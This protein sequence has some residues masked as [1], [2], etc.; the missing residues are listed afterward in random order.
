MSGSS[1]S[2]VRTYCNARPEREG[3]QASASCTDGRERGGG[4]DCSDGRVD[5]CKSS[6]GSTRSRIA[7]G[8]TCRAVFAAYL[9][10]RF[11]GGHGPRL[12]GRHISMLST[13][14]QGRQGTENSQL[15]QLPCGRLP[16][17]S[18]HKGSRKR[19][20]WRPR[21]AKDMIRPPSCMR[22]LWRPRLAKGAIRVPPRSENTACM[23]CRFHC[24]FIVLRTERV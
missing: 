18:M 14:G 15:P 4:V 11:L 5:G 13:A 20:F 10:T 22:E 7:L 16:F 23:L 9:E 12:A 3:A 19:E 17:L 8:S 6:R 2:C 1:S 21:L 24:C